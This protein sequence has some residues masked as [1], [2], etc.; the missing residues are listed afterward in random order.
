MDVSVV[1]ATH[2]RHDG[3]ARAVTSVL[4]QQPPAREVIVC[5]DGSR[6]ETRARFTA[7][8]QEEPRLIYMRRP[9][10]AGGPGPA[11]NMGVKAAHGRWVAFLDD[12]DEWLAGK[13]AAQRS[14]AEGGGA[15]VIA[16]NALRSSGTVYF[17][18]LASPWMPSRRELLHDNPLIL[19]SVMVRRDLVAATK[20]FPVSRRLAGI[21]DYL[22]WL[23]L[24][25]RGARFI[26]LPD[27]LVRYA[28]ATDNARMSDPA[29][30]LQ[31]AI[32]QTSWSRWSRRPWDTGLLRAAVN[33]SH[34]A[35][36]SWRERT[37]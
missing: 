6:D 30:H 33:Q 35:W 14:W 23:A 26:V 13:L 21:E 10:S 24:S 1:I 28:D 37:R 2:N 31:V 4:A 3:C 9:E 18:D 32:A 36:G 16:T 12:D 11:R 19:S 17:P 7:W 25:D 15:D 22:L 8:A 29:V 34:K 20:G 27:V 5:D